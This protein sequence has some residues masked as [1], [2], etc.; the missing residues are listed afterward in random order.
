MT[1]E[2][3]LDALGTPEAWDPPPDLGPLPVELVSRARETFEKLAAQVKAVEARLDQVVG[4]IG[5]LSMASGEP[6]TPHYIDTTA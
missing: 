4:E 3:A 6:N 5:D 2:E 1:W